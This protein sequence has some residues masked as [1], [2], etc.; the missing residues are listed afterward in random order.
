MGGKRF[1]SDEELENAVTTWLNELETEEYDVGILKLVDRYD[2]CLNIGVLR[3]NA[4]NGYRRKTKVQTFR[5][6]HKILIGFSLRR[7][8][9]ERYAPNCV[10][11]CAPNCVERCAPNCVERCAPNC[12]ERCAPNCVERC[13]P[14]CV[15]QSLCR[16]GA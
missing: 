1:G 16:T 2:K 6:H 8:V 9:L 3:P 12:V 7:R 15:G 5:P 4:P 11:R 10:K 13:A 14:N